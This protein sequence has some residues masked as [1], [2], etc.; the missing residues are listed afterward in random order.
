MDH[1][2]YERMMKPFVKV[3]P[4]MIRDREMISNT[5]RERAWKRLYVEDNR[6]YQLRCFRA[7]YIDMVRRR[8]EWSGSIL[9]DT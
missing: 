2:G 1:Y 6:D 3:T 7:D 4:D 5:N 8:L 9:G